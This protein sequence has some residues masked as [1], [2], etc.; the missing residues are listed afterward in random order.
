MASTVHPDHWK[1]A[2]IAGNHRA[3][4]QRDV[5]GVAAVPSFHILRSDLLS[6]VTFD[7]ALNECTRHDGR[8]DALIGESISI[9]K[10]YMSKLMGGVWSGQMKRLVAFMRET[11]CIAP[12]QV[13]AREMGCELVV[14]SAA[15]AEIDRLEAALA[16]ARRRAA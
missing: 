10:G 3:F 7:G 9:S 8:T 1:P 15:Q 4:V 5:G 16:D 2:D 14:K 12:L 11:N 13:L 6:R